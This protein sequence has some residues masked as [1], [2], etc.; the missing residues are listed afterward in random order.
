MESAEPPPHPR[1]EPRCARSGPAELRWRWSSAWSHYAAPSSSPDCSPAPAGTENCCSPSAAGPG[2]RSQAA[3]RSSGGQASASGF[4][5]E[6]GCAPSGRSFR[7][8]TAHGAQSGCAPGVSPAQCRG[9]RS[10]G[11][12]AAGVS[13]A[14]AANAERSRDCRRR[15]ECA[16]SSGARRRRCSRTASSS[17]PGTP[18]RNHAADWTAPGVSGAASSAC[19]AGPNPNRERSPAT[20]RRHSAR[21]A[22]FRSRPPRWTPQ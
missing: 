9:C 13:C 5:S 19:D 2:H 21:T 12:T 16:A 17:G 18:S 22:D 11:F 7:R 6:C 4:C 20:G 8:C 1:L 15:R 3:R 10:S 14:P